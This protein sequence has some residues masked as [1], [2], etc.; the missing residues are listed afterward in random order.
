MDDNNSL[1]AN[2]LAR[3]NALRATNIILDKPTAPLSVP[4]PEQTPET[5]LSARL[6]S[7]R[8]ANENGNSSQGR[9]SSPLSP[10]RE[11]R[12]DVKSSG[13]ERGLNLPSTPSTLE[14]GEKSAAHAIL[15]DS[16]RTAQELAADINKSKF[17][18]D[19]EKDEQLT[20]EALSFTKGLP[21]LR[22]GIEKVSVPR[23]QSWRGKQDSEK[24]SKEAKL[25]LEK[26]RAVLEGGEIEKSNGD[27]DSDEE[28]GDKEADPQI[29]K[30][31]QS[32]DEED[33]RELNEDEE[34]DLILAQLMDE[35]EFDLGS[36]AETEPI[37]KPDPEPTTKSTGSRH[38][39][40]KRKPQLPSP[41]KD[42]KEEDDDKAF[43]T[44]MTTRLSALKSPPTT[45]PSNPNP[46]NPLDLPS[47][48]SV[49][50][51]NTLGL[52]SAPITKPG[53]SP[54]PPSLPKEPE[55]ICTI[56]YAPG[57]LLC[58]GCL[59][60]FEEEGVGESREEREEERG[61]A[62]FCA[63]CWKEGHLGE[64]AVGGERWHRFESLGRGK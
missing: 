41:P 2:L 29:P 43:T 6:K 3:L 55:Q 52:P 16:E 24:L 7:L 38:A 62:T 20:R 54:F 19:A 57:T 46:S 10:D 50:P 11:T 51:V 48:P 12:N 64:S 60:M 34:A 49:E 58:L 26:S 45:S 59:S 13:T 9:V 17:G 18:N 61:E 47:A 8:A 31:L 15:S 14:G 4:K 33:P 44:L 28:L 35:V 40:D 25:A 22:K 39:V 42:A 36:E 30:Q 32:D 21:E 53:L 5:E 27:D 63:R 37:P 56:C 1:D 23:Q